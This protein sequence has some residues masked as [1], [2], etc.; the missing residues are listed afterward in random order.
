MYRSEAASPD[1]WRA[2]GNNTAST[3]ERTDQLHN[4]TPSNMLSRRSIK[5]GES[6]IEE[7][8]QQYDKRKQLTTD[9]VEN[10]DMVTQRTSIAHGLVASLLENTGAHGIPNIK[11]APNTFRRLIWTGLFLLGLAMF[12]WQT[13][14]LL[15]RYYSYGVD[16]KLD[17][18]SDRRIAFPAVT[19]CNL[20][21]IKSDYIE[22]LV[23]G[24][25]SLPPSLNRPTL[26]IIKQYLWSLN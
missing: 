19:I 17:I 2:S 24:G 8:S 9:M 7:G 25:G 15:Q 20:N 11:R 12:L 22:D 26:V 14:W 13:S 16:V 5:R 18:S 4:S 23:D 21:G 6:L 10:E 3:C 1:N